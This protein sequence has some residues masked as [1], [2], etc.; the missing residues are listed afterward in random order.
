[1]LSWPVYRIYPERI[2]LSGTNLRLL[3]EA[4]TRAYSLSPALTNELDYFRELFT[5]SD[6]QHALAK[7]I[8]RFLKRMMQFTGPLTA[9]GVEDTTFYIYN[10]L[11]SHVEV[12]DTPTTL[13][14]SVRSFHRRMVR[15]RE[16]NPQ[17][18][19]A[20]ATHDTKRGEDA[21]MRLNLLSEIPE[22]WTQRVES[23]RVMNAPLIKVN[24][25]QRAPSIND[26]YFIYQ[27]M[28][29]GFP[30]DFVISESWI[31]R[32]Q[33]YIV[34]VV[35]EAKVISSWSDPDI[36]YEDA[37]QQ[38]IRNVLTSHT[39]FIEDFLPFITRLCRE[40]EMYSVSQLLVKITTPGIPD[41]YQG[42][43][44]FDLSYVDPDNRRPVDF[45]I[46]LQILN[47]ISTYGPKGSDTLM[48]W[49]NSNTDIGVR[50][51]FTALRMLNFRRAHSDL[52]AKGA[53]IAL[54]C[55]GS[56]LA[57]ARKWVDEWLVVIIPLGIAGKHSH[58][59]NLPDVLISPPLDFPQV[60]NNIF[61]DENVTSDQGF[62]VGTL[63][64][65][66]PVVALYT[67]SSHNDKL[68]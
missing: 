24:G 58:N 37:C 46:R 62:S 38:F 63:T 51:F 6:P 44:L 26:E 64:R 41:L 33:E 17:S 30:E 55:A 28:V 32:L 65:K 40:A 34:K 53:Y 9:K 67:R 16:L 66:F 13:G 14:I 12:G 43:E 29:G 18:L 61:T 31:Q 8:I 3:N 50:K 7:N 19:N 36:D 25:T 48:A 60:W 57:Y 49:L 4:F 47:D 45:Q 2:P 35:R 52:F 68:P 15:R 1:M 21:R 42:T 59:K 54:E 5:I 23:W 27:S 11:I 10:P 20:T 22:E 56:V 39:S